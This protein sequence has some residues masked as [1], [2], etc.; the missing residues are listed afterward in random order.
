MTCK[1]KET[2]LLLMKCSMII[3]LSI[4]LIFSTTF[5]INILNENIKDTPSIK[6]TTNNTSKKRLN[7][8]K[9]KHIS[10]RININS[11]KKDRKNNEKES[12][13]NEIDGLEKS[14]LSTFE[15][16]SNFKICGNNWI[17][18]LFAFILGAFWNVKNI[19]KCGVI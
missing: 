15:K 6:A 13:F 7:N 14:Q 17:L 10:T 8:K 5:T 12:T 9:N 1:Q 19:K 4:L 2:Y 18:Y 3:Y 16:I 11:S